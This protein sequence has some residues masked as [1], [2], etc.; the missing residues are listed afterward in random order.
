MDGP[1][2]PKGVH[3]QEPREILELAIR[4]PYGYSSSQPSTPASSAPV[5]RASSFEDLTRLEGSDATLLRKGMQGRPSALQS[6]THEIM[7]IIFCSF[8]QLWTQINFGNM[9]VSLLKVQEDLHLDD[10][11]LPWLTGAFALANGSFVIFFGSMADKIGAKKVYIGGCLWLACWSVIAGLSRGAIQ[12]FVSRAMHGIAGG[13]LIPSG[14]GLLGYFYEPGQRKNRV[15]STFGAMAPIGFIVGALEGGIVTSFTSWSWMFYFNAI[16]LIPFSIAAYFII[17]ADEP[18]NIKQNLRSFD[19][20]GSVIAIS[21]LCLIVF[22]LTDGPV[23][24]WA[25]YTY[26]LL[27]VGIL[28]MIIFVL[29]EKSIAEHPIMPLEIWSTKSFGFL[30]VANVLGWG[31][32]AAWQ[33]YVSL[34]YLKIQGASPLLTAAYFLPNAVIGVVATFVCASTLHVLPGMSFLSFTQNYDLH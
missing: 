16:L 11:Q 9:T 13:A 30:M 24:S 15:F 22:G 23:A 8:A 19:W 3:F 10:T 14:I 28:L 20:L 12:L 29:V 5:S 33:F 6:T 32:Y 1:V 27:I 31:A 21:G 25:P 17:P 4:R 18:R 2:K 7:F 34:F 26:S